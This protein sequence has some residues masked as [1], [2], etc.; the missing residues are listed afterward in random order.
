[1]PATWL[2]LVVFRSQWDLP[3][4]PLVICGSIAST[5]GRTILA[6]LAGILGERVLPARFRKNLDALKSAL[7]PNSGR[8]FWAVLGLTIAPLPSNELFI[9]AGLVKTDLRPIAAGFFISRLVTYAFALVAAKNVSTTLADVFVPGGSA[10]KS[11]IGLLISLLPMVLMTLIP[12]PRV[13][14]WA[15]KASK[16]KTAKPSHGDLPASGPDPDQPSTLQG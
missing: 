14:R 1:M 10:G 2:V 8:T 5:T 6:W 15:G 3:L 13:F 11:F 16:I 9:A 7:A 4:I 12:W